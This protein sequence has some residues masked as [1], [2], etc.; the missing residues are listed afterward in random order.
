MDKTSKD[1]RCFLEKWLHKSVKQYVSEMDGNEKG[2][3]Y[4]LLVCGLEKPLLEIVLEE[5]QGNQTK[6]AN[7][8]GINRNTLRKKV[9]EYRIQCKAKV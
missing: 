7:I 5:T 3:L 4:G 1:I 6:A 2:D 9:Q 8:L